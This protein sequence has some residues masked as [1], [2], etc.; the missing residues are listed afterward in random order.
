MIRTIIDGSNS[1]W[2]IH[3]ID[4]VS[5]S[6][7]NLRFF[8]EISELFFSIRNT[9]GQLLL[10][11]N[12]ELGETIYRRTKVYH[13]PLEEELEYMDAEH[14]SG[15]KSG[16]IFSAQAQEAYEGHS[17][18]ISL[19]CAGDKLYSADG[20]FVYQLYNGKLCREEV[21]VTSDREDVVSSLV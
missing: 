5:D 13:I 19:V 12:R 1:V 16:F 3:R 4:D 17:A 21:S 18:D 2:D 15:F 8:V 7:T 14:L 6:T 11:L 10:C 20:R 9:Q